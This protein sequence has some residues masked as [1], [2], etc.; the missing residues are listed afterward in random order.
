MEHE[1]RTI[2]EADFRQK[3]ALLR[4]ELNVPLSGKEI[5]DDTRIRDTLP[6]IRH[7]LGSG[8]SRL[9]IMAHL[10]RPKGQDPS[11]SMAP[12]AQRLSELVEWEV[13]LASPDLDAALPDSRIVMLENLRFY[14]G[15][16]KGDEGFARKLASLGDVYVNDAF[17]VC[18]RQDSSVAAVPGFLPSYAGLLLEKEISS[19]SRVIGNPERPFCFVLGCAKVSDKIGLIESMVSRCDY[20]LLGGAIVF[21]FLRAMGYETGKSLVDEQ[22]IATA[23]SILER[24]RN[25]IIIPADFVAAR[26]KD[27]ESEVIETLAAELPPDFIGLDLGPKSIELFRNILGRSK[28]VVWNGPLGVYELQRFA[29]ATKEIGDFIAGLDAMTLAGGGDTVS[30]INL[31]GIRNGFTHISTG[32]GAFLAFIEGMKMPGIEALSA[33]GK[34]A[35]DSA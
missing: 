33:H 6:T 28:T 17:G 25:K 27:S 22:S 30:A 10:G 3:R 15:E 13:A 12:V 14:E 29:R 16:K 34:H 19:I 2:R 9:I 35:G 32:G 7:I 18:H 31:L 24:H 5:A 23:K 26:E 11:L 21:T 1:I 4:A 20:L 8:A